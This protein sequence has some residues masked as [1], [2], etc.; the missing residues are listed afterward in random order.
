MAKA[1]SLFCS[2]VGCRTVHRAY[3]TTGVH[4]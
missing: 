4:L 1:R 2:A 3:G